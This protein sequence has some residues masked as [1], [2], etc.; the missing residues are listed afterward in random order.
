MSIFT[1]IMVV[2]IQHTFV[3][4][5]GIFGVFSKVN[6]NTDTIINSNPR[7]LVSNITG[8]IDSSLLVNQKK[9]VKFSKYFFEKNRKFWNVSYSFSEY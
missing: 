6:H 1:P 2:T 9:S 4:P 5:N 3:K 7:G 8:N